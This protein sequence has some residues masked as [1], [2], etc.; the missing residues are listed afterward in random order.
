MIRK[1]CGIN[2]LFL[3]NEFRDMERPIELND[4]SCFIYEETIKQ[5]TPEEIAKILS[6]QFGISKEDALKDVEYCL[7]ELERQHVFDK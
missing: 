3:D 4:T 1:V 2:Y 6:T 7:Q 5:K